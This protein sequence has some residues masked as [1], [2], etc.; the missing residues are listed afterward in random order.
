MSC[1]FIDFMGFILNDDSWAIKEL[2]VIS[3]KKK[4][5]HCIFSPP[6]FK[7]H[8]LTEKAKNINKFLSTTQHQLIWTEG[9]IPFCPVCTE[10]AILEKF[11]RNTLFY[12]VQDDVKYQTLKNNFPNL[13]L[14]KYNIPLDGFQ[15]LRKSYCPILHNHY[16]CALNKSIIMLK[17]Y[18]KIS[19]NL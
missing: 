19:K 6:N 18:I 13:R 9:K 3:T 14:V 16:Y 17:N 10:K 8:K 4:Y 1:A 11:G 15:P 7:Y 5:I 2:A 12:T